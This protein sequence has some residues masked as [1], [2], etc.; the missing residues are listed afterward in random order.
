MAAGLPEM[1]LQQQHDQKDTTGEHNELL[2]K[3]E[4]Q[5]RLDYE[6]LKHGDNVEAKRITRRFPNFKAN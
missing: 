1:T 4:A 2:D 5:S 3:I 6:N